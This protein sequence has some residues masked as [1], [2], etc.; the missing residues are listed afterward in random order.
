[1]PYVVLLL[2]DVLNIHA[3]VCVE[4]D[5]HNPQIVS[6]RIF[7]FISLFLQYVSAQHSVIIYPY[8]FV[9]FK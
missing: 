5:T 3:V 7:A 4:I 9:K 2:R 1:M 8:P 6:G